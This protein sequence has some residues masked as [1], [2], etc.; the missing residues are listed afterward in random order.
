MTDDITPEKTAAELDE[1]AARDQ[2]IGAIPG[3]YIDTWSM[4]SWKGHIRVT[5]GEIFHDTDNFRTAIVMNIDDAVIFARRMLRMAERRKARD[6]EHATRDS[7]RST[8]EVVEAASDK[9]S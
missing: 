2:E 4:Y 7:E 3:L 5:F 8:K 6:L 1:E 9:E